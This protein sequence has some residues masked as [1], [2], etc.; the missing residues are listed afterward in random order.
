MKLKFN[1]RSLVADRN[2]LFKK[3]LLLSL[4]LFIAQMGTALM[5]RSLIGSSP[6]ATAVDGISTMLSISKGASNIVLNTIFLIVA[7]IVN[8]KSIGI[9]TIIAVVQ[10]G[11]FLDIWLAI[12]P[13]MVIDQMS[14]RIMLNILG[15]F[16]SAMGIAFYIQFNIGMGPLE[17]MVDSI[18][19][20]SGLDYRWSRYIFD[21]LLLLLGILFR[22][23]F[24]LGTILNLVLMGYF[25]QR[26]I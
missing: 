11:L 3:I 17:L 2:A 5:Y 14:I 6:M 9:G 15:T 10:F 23:V 7:F 4:G 12:I 26:F 16:F 19:L 22:G 24:G 25:L 8:R 20:K 21:G 18:H 1:F 13:E